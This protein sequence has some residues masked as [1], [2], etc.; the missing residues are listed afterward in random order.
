[1]L[2]VVGVVLVVISDLSEVGGNAALKNLRLA[3]SEGVPY[4][5]SSKGV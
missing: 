4:S 2:A 3:Q 5:V 1:M